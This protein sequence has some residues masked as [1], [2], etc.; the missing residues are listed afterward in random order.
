MR[1]VKTPLKNLFLWSSLG[2]VVVGATFAAARRKNRPGQPRQGCQPIPA[3]CERVYIWT[4]PA[5]IRQNGNSLVLRERYFLQLTA[6]KVWSVLDLPAAAGRP[7]EGGATVYHVT[8]SRL[9]EPAEGS[10]AGEESVTRFYGT[11]N[12]VTVSGRACGKN[13]LARGAILKINKCYVGGASNG[14]ETGDIH[15]SAAPILNYRFEY[16]RGK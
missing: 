11:V 8:H 3:G 10:P 12:A 7:G 15:R 16:A 6:F 13:A 1:F 9:L 4:A 5:E 14:V 2:S